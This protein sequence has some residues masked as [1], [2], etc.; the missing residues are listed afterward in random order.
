MPSV[1]IIQTGK[2]R[3]RARQR[4]CLSGRSRTMRLQ[5]MQLPGAVLMEIAGQVLPT[6]DQEQGGQGM[7]NPRPGKGVS[8]FPFCLRGLRSVGSNQPTR[9]R[10][11]RDCWDFAIS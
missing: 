3:R 6:P 4:T 5:I 2:Q 10:C 7:R 1:P 8:C 9:P 11:A